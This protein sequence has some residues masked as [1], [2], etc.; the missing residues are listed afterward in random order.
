MKILIIEDDPKIIEIVTRTFET[1]WSEV[2]LISTFYGDE[3]VELVK[4]ELPDIVILD[5]MLPDTDGFQVLWKIRSFSDVLVV[6][7][8]AKGEEDNR[9]RGL[10]EGAD[11]YIV[12]PFSAGELVARI[13][14][15]IRRREMT[16]TT[17]AV[18]MKPS[19]KSKLSIDT[20]NEMAT[21]GDKLLRMG[22][23]Q[24]EL[25]YLLVTN[26]GVMLPKQVL[27]KKVFPEND[28]SDTRFVDVYIKKLR[29]VLEE[30]PDTPKMILNEG[31]EG[32]KFVGSYSMVREALK[33]TES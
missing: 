3:G 5:L 17:A 8:T 6:I 4:K 18:V 11:D 19:T 31:T 22:P 27:M 29:E 21:I 12:K 7:L 10:Q 14:S 16:E 23:R 15:L 13:K 24:Y 9:I 26:E 20:T 32:Y 30:D 28:G 1:K 33:E 2:N 25:L